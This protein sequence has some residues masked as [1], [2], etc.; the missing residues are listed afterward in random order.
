MQAS[1]LKLFIASFNRSD[2]FGI[3]TLHASLSF[4]RGAFVLRAEQA[5][6]KQQ[7]V[8]SQP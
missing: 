2:F 3:Y 8:G 4:L 7:E 1:I 6:T 5:V